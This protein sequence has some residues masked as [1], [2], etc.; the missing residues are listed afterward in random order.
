MF[1][2]SLRPSKQKDPMNIR[3]SLHGGARTSLQTGADGLLN[4]DLG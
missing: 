2:S 3:F 1:N 4:I